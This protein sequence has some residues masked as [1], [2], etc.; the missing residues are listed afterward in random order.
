MKQYVQYFLQQHLNQF[1][2]TNL[3]MKIIFLLSYHQLFK[4]CNI[5]WSNFLIFTFCLYH[6]H[7]TEEFSGGQKIEEKKKSYLFILQLN[8]MR[9][10]NTEYIRIVWKSFFFKKKEFNL[11]HAKWFYFY[12]KMLQKFSLS[13]FLA[14]N[15]WPFDFGNFFYSS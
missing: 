4:I 10:W 3:L 14:D 7:K 6:I 5:L 15:F 11:G 13:N 1:L 2:P 12:F 8:T 9:K